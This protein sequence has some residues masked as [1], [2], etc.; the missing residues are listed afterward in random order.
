MLHDL[1]QP[2]YS[3]ADCPAWARETRPA[4]LTPFLGKNGVPEPWHSEPGALADPAVSGLDRYQANNFIA[5]RPET[6]KY[7]YSEY[8]PLKVQLHKGVAADV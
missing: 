3:P 6:A 5:Y 7:L 2:A 1:S 8:T 4:W